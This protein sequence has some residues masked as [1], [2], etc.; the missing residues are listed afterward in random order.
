MRAGPIE[1]RYAKALYRVCKNDLALAKKCKDELANIES[2]FALEDAKKVLVSPV[3]PADLKTALLGEAT[4]GASDIV[5]NY[6]STVVGASRTAQLPGII[7]SF[8]NLLDEKEGI[9]NA[10]I[11]TAVDVDSASVSAIAAA[12]SDKKQVTIS[13]R[14]DPS[15]LGGLIVKVGNAVVN[16]SLKKQLN[17]LAKA[18]IS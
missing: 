13:Q 12:I 11:T 3:M 16:M 9:L 10:E 6:V 15:I 17:S 14:V 1:R 8:K 18:T 7:E 4:K 5:V 2:L